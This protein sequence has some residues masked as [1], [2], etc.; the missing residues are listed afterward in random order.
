MNATDIDLTHA[1]DDSD[2]A[3]K[4]AAPEN[5]LGALPLLQAAALGNRE[6]VNAI[7]ASA[8]DAR[9]LVDERCVFGLSALHHALR[10]AAKIDCDEAFELCLALL[11]SCANVNATDAAHFT[12][13]T[14]VAIWSANEE[15]AL[16]VARTLVEHGADVS[17]V[18][19]ENR[20][21]ADYALL[22]GM[23]ALSAWLRE[24]AVVANHAL[25]CNRIR[26]VARAL[27][28]SRIV[29]DARDRGAFGCLTRW[30]DVEIVKAL[31]GSHVTETQSFAIA[32][33]IKSRQ[34]FASLEDLAGAMLGDNFR[35]LA[36]HMPKT[37]EQQTQR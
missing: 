16:K 21:P 23:P 3:T 4:F 9:T 35:C 26:S 28:K 27:A 10:A 7:L 34:F 5:E 30:L 14:T 11:R 19:C 37:A 13:L 8:Q 17:I 29:C 25:M 15:Q 24:P 2:D 12:P 20:S 18:M 32:A 6:Q 31:A 22:Y 33:A 36:R 1:V